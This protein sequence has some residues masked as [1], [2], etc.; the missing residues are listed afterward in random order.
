[1][2]CK[3]LT[4]CTCSNNPITNLDVF[5]NTLLE[6]LLIDNTQISSIASSVL[7]KLK[8]L[9]IYH[10]N[11]SSLKISSPD[12]N[13]LWIG[14]TPLSSND[15]ATMEVV[16]NLPARESNAKGYLNCSVNASILSAVQSVCAA[17]NWDVS[18]HTPS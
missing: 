17:K 7:T 15:T 9:Y 8:R 5:D 10:T 14:N 2:Y 13:E 3:E 4:Y 18:N 11:I 16:N 6:V 1:M 12:L